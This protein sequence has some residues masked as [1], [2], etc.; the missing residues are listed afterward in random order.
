MV[1]PSGGIITVERGTVNNINMAYKPSQS[2]S[3]NLRGSCGT[4]DG[5]RASDVTLRDGST[6]HMRGRN[7]EF[8]ESWR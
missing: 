8:V 4:H 2:E 3:G 6:G 7:D 1:L 5:N